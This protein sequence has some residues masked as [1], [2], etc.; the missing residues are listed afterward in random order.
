LGNSLI[1]SKGAFLDRLACWARQPVAV[2]A[3]M[4]SLDP[5]TRA[6]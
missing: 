6:A 3:D 1:K 5:D 2:E 4:K